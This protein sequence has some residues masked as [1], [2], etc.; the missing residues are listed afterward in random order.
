MTVFIPKSLI[1]ETAADA[2]AKLTRVSR[3][4]D[5]A[6]GQIVQ[7]NYA[8]ER[9]TQERRLVDLEAAAESGPLPDRPDAQRRLTQHRAKMAEWD[10][11]RGGLWRNLE[12]EIVQLDAERV[13]L[14]HYL[15]DFVGIQ[16]GR[17]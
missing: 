13:R 8:H 17:G 7:G 2:A 12:A 10:R 4:L 11:E 1:S 16:V 15:A 14:E 3:R 5:D 6:R 9:S